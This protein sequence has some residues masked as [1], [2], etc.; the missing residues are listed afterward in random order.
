M[1]GT[2]QTPSSYVDVRH[3]DCIIQPES[4]IAQEQHAKTGVKAAKYDIHDSHTD[5][6]DVW[7][8]M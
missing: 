8:Q 6:S 1:T 7:T 3:A 5:D 4:R 2:A